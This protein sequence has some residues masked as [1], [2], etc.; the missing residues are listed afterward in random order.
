VLI[1]FRCI[2]RLRCIFLGGKEWAGTS[3]IYWQAPPVIITVKM[4]IIIVFWREKKRWLLIMN[5]TFALHLAFSVDNPNT[6]ILIHKLE[7]WSRFHHQVVRSI[8][9]QYCSPIHIHIL[10]TKNIHNSRWL[11]NY[12]INLL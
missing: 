6:R 12:I 2:K 11:T 4:I 7:G 3:G 1:A 8:S 5:T 9:I 10:R